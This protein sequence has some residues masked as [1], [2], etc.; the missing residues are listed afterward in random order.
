MAQTQK[1]YFVS[2]CAYK[3]L[4]KRT[5]LKLQKKKSKGNN[6]VFFK[7]HKHYL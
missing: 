4:L 3:N 1:D 7:F 6:Q 2:F 5:Q